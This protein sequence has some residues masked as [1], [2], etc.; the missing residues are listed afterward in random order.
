ML[1]FN[2]WILFGWRLCGG[3]IGKIIGFICNFIWVMGDDRLRKKNINLYLKFI[4]IY[5]C[6]YLFIYSFILNQ[7]GAMALDRPL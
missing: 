2:L 5:I 1:R 7:I 4:Y 6:I 3:Q